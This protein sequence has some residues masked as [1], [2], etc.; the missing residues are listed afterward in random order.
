MTT[1]ADPREYDFGADETA[2]ELPE[3][4]PLLT[5]YRDFWEEKTAPY[6]A[7]LYT[8]SGLDRTTVEL[9]MVALMALRSWETGVRA[10]TR[11]ALDAGCSAEEIRGAILITLG[12][13]GINTAARGIAWAEPVIESRQG[14]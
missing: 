6:F 7:E 1:R 8:T 9:I 10:H 13:G 5:H 14:S 11:L 4:V 3:M 12:V 2:R